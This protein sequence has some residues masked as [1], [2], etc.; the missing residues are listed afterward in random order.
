MFLQAEGSLS[1]AFDWQHLQPARGSLL[2]GVARLPRQL[3]GSDSSVPS[4]SEATQNARN[5]SDLLRRFREL[6]ERMRQEYRQP[7]VLSDVEVKLRVG[8]EEEGRKETPVGGV[9]VVLSDAEVKLRV[10]GEEEGEERNARP[11]LAPHPPP[12]R[13]LP[14]A[15]SPPPPPSTP[16]H[17]PTPPQE[18][19]VGI[20]DYGEKL[21]AASRRAERVV[22]EFEELGQVLGD[23]GLSFVKLAKYEDEEGSKLGAYTPLGAGARAG[24]ND[25]RRVGV[26]GVRLAR[27]SRLA[28]GQVCG[29]GWGGGVGGGGGVPGASPVSVLLL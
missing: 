22:R 2:E 5:T 8:G 10:G 28:T 27:L 25:A 14:P 11:T 29:G 9:G 24:A 1:A 19:K 18:E 21:A 15:S 6:G 4:V 12:T 3:I 20:E 16:L 17:P 7:P 23:L 26:N 13:L